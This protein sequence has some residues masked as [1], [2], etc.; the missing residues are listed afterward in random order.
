MMKEG[1]E[2][3][4]AGIGGGIVAAIQKLRAEKLEL[5]ET[6]QEASPPH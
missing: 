4:V 3:H 5:G 1:F 6:V 2:P